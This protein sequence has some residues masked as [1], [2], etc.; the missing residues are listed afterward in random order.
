[1]TLEF[2]IDR[3]VCDP[4]INNTDCNVKEM[5]PYHGSDFK[6]SSVVAARGLDN[7]IC[8]DIVNSTHYG[9]GIRYDKHYTVPKTNY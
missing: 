3:S 2:W 1:M 5:Y 9:L 8:Y 7:F 4:V 6:M